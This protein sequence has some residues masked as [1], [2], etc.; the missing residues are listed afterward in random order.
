VAGPAGVQ[1]ILRIFSEEIARTL[2][3]MGVGSLDELGPEWLERAPQT[4]G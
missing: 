4:T 1:A 2:T 3:L